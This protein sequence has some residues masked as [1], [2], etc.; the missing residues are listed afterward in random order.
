MMLILMTTLSEIASEALK[1]SVV[2][3]CLADLNQDEDQA[4]RKFKLRIEDVQGR[5]CLTS[6]HGMSLTTDKLR[7]LVRKWQTLIETHVDVK[8][9]DGWVAFGALGLGAL[10]LC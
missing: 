9:T 4:H 3:A 8:T 10:G 5:L 2:E 7:S 6:F 1:G